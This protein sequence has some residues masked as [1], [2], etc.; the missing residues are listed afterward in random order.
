MLS[1]RLKATLVA[2]ALTVN[3]T[4]AQSV[5]LLRDPDIEHGLQ[6]LANPILRAAGLNGEAI[7]V[8]IVNDM[9]LTCLRDRP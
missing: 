8:L 5:G 6:K 9:S 4:T 7:K 3:A 1:T 2:I